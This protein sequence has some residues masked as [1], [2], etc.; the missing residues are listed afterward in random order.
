MARG[1]D[2]K[3]AGG[4]RGH[5]GTS[6]SS[7]SDARFAS[8]ASDPRF[9]RPKKQDRKLKLD[10]RFKGVLKDKDFKQ[11]ARVDKYGRRIHED[12]DAARL[13]GLYDVEDDEDE[14]E[15]ATRDVGLH[16]D[17]DGDE[18]EDG[19]EEDEE[20]KPRYDPA[21]GEGVEDSSDEEEDL[22]DDIPV[23]G[24]DLADPEP[25]RE[26]I[27]RGDVTRRFAIV[28]LDWDNLDAEDLYMAMG[29]FKPAAGSVLSVKI[30]P[31][32]FGKERM[33]NEDAAGPPSD[34]FKAAGNEQDDEDRPINAASI[35]KES[36]GEEF[37]MNKLRKY[38]LERLR[39]YYAVVEC[40][41]VA[42]ARHIYNSCDGAE[43]ESSANF[44]DLRFIPDDT[45]FDE[46]D[47]TD[48]CDRPPETYEPNEF[49]TDALQHSKVKLT[50]DADDPKRQQFAKKAFSRA[51][52]DDMELK[53]YLASDSEEEEDDKEQRRSKWRALLAGEDGSDGEE[54]GGGAFSSKPTGNMQVT[55]APGL[56]NKKANVVEKDPEEETTLEKYQRKQKERRQK[57]KERKGLEVEEEAKPDL[58]FDD[59]FFD[60]TPSSKSAVEKKEKQ[61]RQEEKRKN[62]ELDDQKKAELELLMDD[63]EDVDGKQ[64]SHFDMKTILKAEKTAGKKGKFAKRARDKVSKMEGLQDDFDIDVADPRFAAAFDTDN[65]HFAI[66]P[67]NPRFVKTKAMDKVLERRRGQGDR[68]R[69]P[70]RRR[71]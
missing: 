58:G 44:F 18:D 14:E 70:K 36:L 40:D 71:H 41:S 60:D 32:E 25:D 33:A 20:V 27:P 16:E 4:S 49:V 68:E 63:D 67:T 38:Q 30:Y 10:S 28:N 15:E 56:S 50:W 31:S 13:K 61:Q 62:K 47:V 57:K 9:H 5:N 8:L 19:E 59:P 17:S 12:K 22:P 45:T 51:E 46:D 39:Y 11:T 1:E 6:N 37:D 64:K 52:I 66:D 35:V 43:Y 65:H 34:I 48:S 26:N 21:R 42:T 24:R 54:D 2:R 69:D 29:S 7:A 55:F 53:A 23:D 3:K